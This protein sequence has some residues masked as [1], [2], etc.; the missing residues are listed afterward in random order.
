MTQPTMLARFSD[1]VLGGTLR[2][3]SLMAGFQG[4]MCG[5]E[6]AV[7][8]LDT[9]RAVIWNKQLTHCMGAAAREEKKSQDRSWD[10]IFWKAIDV[11]GEY[12]HQDP[13]ELVKQGAR[14]IAIAIVTKTIADRT[15]GAPIQG[16]NLVGGF[17]GLQVLATGI[18]ENIPSFEAWRGFFN[19]MPV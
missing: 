12:K 13:M 7:R 17:I 19:R 16:F 8:V 4:A 1:I 14:Y 15:V 6:L 2:V 10:D 11:R 5:L 9:A 18:L 3:T